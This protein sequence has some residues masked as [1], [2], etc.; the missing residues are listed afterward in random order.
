VL[1][2]VQLGAVSLFSQES[3]S[4][5]LAS[6]RAAR[7]EEISIVAVGDVM[8]G[9]WVTPVLVQRGVLYPFEATL[10]YLR[11][12]DAAIA[13]LEA[14][15]TR[16]GEPFEKQFNFKVPPEHAR[17][18]K[19]AGLDVVTL[20]NNHILDYGTV[21]LVST[22]ATLD[23]FGLKYSG[24][25]RN[26]REAHQPTVIEVRGKT[27]AFF[28]YSTTFPTEFYARGDSAGTAYP[29]AKTMQSALRE[30]DARVD[31]VVA[32]FHWSAEKLE[33]PK[34]YQIEL[35]HLAI[36]SGAD[37]VL[38]HHPHVLQGIE[39]YRNRLI[40]YSLGNFAF[41]SYSSYAVDSII[42]KVYL[43]DDGLFYARC[44]PINVNNS[45][46]EFQPQIL[47]GPRKQAVIAKLQ[48]LS[49]DLNGGQNI[50]SDSGLI[51]GDWR[52]F[53]DRCFPDTAKIADFHS[54]STN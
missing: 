37:L 44:I 45:E 19:N 1:S 21:G 42:L 49:L 30:W 29:E 47:E 54:E 20:A 8:L 12:A 33:I 38:G 22:M 11:G 3:S 5:T 28:G 53:Y 46:V 41:G 14:P 27:I 48:K 16:D 50:L 2:A 52:Q 24:A 40:A 10:P 39:K 13:N 18:L 34:A 25:G 35:A 26:W 32:S 43:N 31:F 7:H 9:S 17:G 15:F 36:D 6:N 51:F 4:T 23:T